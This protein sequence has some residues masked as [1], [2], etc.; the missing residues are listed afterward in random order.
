LLLSGPPAGKLTENPTLRALRWRKI[1]EGKSGDHG[2]AAFRN[3]S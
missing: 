1:T 3:P 2:S